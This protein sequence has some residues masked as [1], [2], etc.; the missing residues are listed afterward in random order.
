MIKRYFAVELKNIKELLQKYNNGGASEAEKEQVEAWYESLEGKE[1]DL[2]NPFVESRL[3]DEI[4][5]SLFSRLNINQEPKRKRLIPIRGI[6]AAAALLI[7]AV[8]IWFYVKPEHGNKSTHTIVQHDI[9]SG[10]NSAVLVL[11][12]G[13]V[14]DLNKNATNSTLG[15]DVVNDLKSGRITY[16]S[17]ERN[18]HPVYNTI[19]TP[20]GGQYQVVL[21]DGTKVWLNALSSVTFPVSFN[22]DKRNVKIEGEAYLEVFKNRKQPFEVEIN[23]M[24]VEVLG[25]HFNVNAYD[26]L[27]KTTLLEGSV[28]VSNI[29]KTVVIK[30]GQQASVG[31][32]QRSIDINQVNTDE[33]IAWKNGYFNFADESLESIMHKVALWYNVEVDYESPELKKLRFMGIIS[34]SRNLSE[35]LNIMKLTG[36]VNFKIENRR[37]LVMHK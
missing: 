29:Y 34:R 23:G 36:N 2:G 12:D 22:G 11:S 4:Q 32:R 37:L 10:G 25:T 3:K 9:P 7:C 14:V 20:R 35:V 30:P 6:A 28:K 27:L 13:S 31:V 16:R 18:A 24:K 1:A 21:P 17:S 33:V 15:Q 19:K 8:A 5:L 26:D